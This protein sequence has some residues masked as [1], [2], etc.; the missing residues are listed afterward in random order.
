M[1]YDDDD[2]DDETSCS[3]NDDD[4]SDNEDSS[5]DKVVEE[6]KKDIFTKVLLPLNVKGIKLACGANHSLV[7]GNDN[8]V[9]AF[10]SN[11]FVSISFFL[12]S[13]IS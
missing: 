12:I 3:D 10:G 13:F 2:D 5:S 8:K 6:K 11:E 1:S 4:T 9:Y 7:L